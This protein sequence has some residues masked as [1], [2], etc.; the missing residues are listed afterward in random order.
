ML[1][2]KATLKQ[3]EIYLQRI[4]TFVCLLG[5]RSKSKFN[6]ETMK[7]YF[8]LIHINCKSISLYKFTFHSNKHYSHIYICCR[9][10][11]YIEANSNHN[12]YHGCSMLWQSRSK[13]SP[14]RISSFFFKLAH[15]ALWTCIPLIFMEEQKKLKLIAVYL[16]AALQ[17]TPL[18]QLMM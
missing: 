12:S 16:L 3:W 14:S 4:A 6:F 11:I 8:I 18:L 1:K 15:Q 2:T 9:P 7:I 10:L 17:R 13:H 5:S